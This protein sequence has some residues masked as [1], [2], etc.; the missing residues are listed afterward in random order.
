ML[1]VHDHDIVPQT[2]TLEIAHQIGIDDGEF[3]GQVGFDRQVAKARFDGS[4]HTDDV[5][6]SGGR[7]NGHAI[8]VAHTVGGDFAAQGFPIQGDAAVDFNIAAARFFQQIE[9]VQRKNTLLPQRAF[10]GGITTAFARQ[11]GRRPV[12]VIAN[13]F[14]GTVGKLHRRL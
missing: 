13:R 4:V 3:A 1:E 11:F 14:H 5:G 10:V 6:N 12:G 8:G 7:R 9:R 2:E